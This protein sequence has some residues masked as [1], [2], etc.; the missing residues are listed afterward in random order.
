[1]PRGQ[2]TGVFANAQLSLPRALHMRSSSTK[3]RG[4]GKQVI[5]GPNTQLSVLSQGH[6]ISSKDLSALNLQTQSL[7][8][9]EEKTRNSVLRGG[10]IEKKKSFTMEDGVW[11]Q[12]RSIQKPRRQP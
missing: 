7:E 8:G 10:N 11:A 4:G 2:S 12:T 1:M 3:W 5:G 6:S 9:E